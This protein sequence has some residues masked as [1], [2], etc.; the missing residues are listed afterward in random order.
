MNVVVVADATAV[1]CPASLEEIHQ[2]EVD[3]LS[4]Q[5]VD[6]PGTAGRPDSL[7]AIDLN[8]RAANEASRRACRRRVARHSAPVTAT[9]PGRRLVDATLAGH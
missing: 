9:L 8:R 1:C 4:R 5:S 6:D 2:R 3:P 7:V